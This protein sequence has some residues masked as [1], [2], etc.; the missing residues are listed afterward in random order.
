MVKEMKVI[1]AVRQSHVRQPCH[2]DRKKCRTFDQMEMP[3]LS[4][5]HCAIANL[6]KA[7]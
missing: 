3:T 5:L 7:R 1:T 2:R 6:T 4:D